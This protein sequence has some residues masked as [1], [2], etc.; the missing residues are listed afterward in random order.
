MNF[1]KIKNM[2]GNLKFSKKNK[3]EKLFV[4]LYSKIR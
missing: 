2:S 4:K 1:C 3:I